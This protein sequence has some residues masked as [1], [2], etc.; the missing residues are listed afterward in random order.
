MKNKITLICL[1][2]TL[3]ISATCNR[4]SSIG[5]EGFYSLTTRMDL[6]GFDE[7]CKRFL[8][9]E[10]RPKWKLHS[11]GEC[12]YDDQP[13]WESILTNKD[14]FIG[15]NRSQMR[16]IFGSPNDTFK[17]GGTVWEK[18]FMGKVCEKYYPYF[19]LQLIYN[20]EG[21]LTNIGRGQI[22]YD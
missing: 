19:T 16:T 3:S 22:T 6:H 7:N 8:K 17:L 20:D 21:V 2:A 4:Q 18:Y 5:N 15:K 13:F 9:K 12:F 1:L 14:C 11:S 10:V